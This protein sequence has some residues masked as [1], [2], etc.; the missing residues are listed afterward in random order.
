MPSLNLFEF[1]NS[2]LIII[3]GLRY[4]VIIK[5]LV[6]KCG[7]V[8]TARLKSKMVSIANAATVP[9][10]GHAPLV[11][12][13]ILLEIP[14]KDVGEERIRLIGVGFQKEPTAN[15]VIAKIVGDAITVTSITQR[16]LTANVET[17]P[18]TGDALTAIVIYPKVLIVS[19]EIVR[20]TG[21]VLAEN[22]FQRELIANVG[23]NNHEIWWFN[24]YY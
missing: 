24:S 18:T 4:V 20:T 19:V 3:N 23:K 6:Y 22:M 17:A 8:K 14:W 7:T 2:M 21:N 13:A 9:T 15:V 1:T 5:I 12:S 16:D 10:I 11:M